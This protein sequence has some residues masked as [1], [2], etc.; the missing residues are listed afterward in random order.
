[1][2]VK[3]QQL[4]KELLI[5]ILTSPINIA[6]DFNSAED[7]RTIQQILEMQKRQLELEIANIKRK[8]YEC[9]QNYQMEV[10]NLLA[11]YFIT[12]P[13][14]V[15]GVTIQLV[16]CDNDNHI[17][18][19]FWMDL[20]LE[21]LIESE[22]IYLFYIYHLNEFGCYVECFLKNREKF[23]DLECNFIML[24]KKISESDELKNL[25]SR[26]KFQDLW[27]VKYQ[28]YHYLV[29]LSKYSDKK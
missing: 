27:S 15:T 24:C 21:I 16:R 25:I 7:C 22:K 14:F 17:I 6:P 23:T 2:Y 3:L 13:E 19:I 8:E 1:M 10:R 5:K 18:K 12:F 11:T 4:P 9:T 20:H 28:S 29:I 26:I